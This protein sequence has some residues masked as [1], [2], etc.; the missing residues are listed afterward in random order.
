MRILHGPINVGNQPWVLSRHERRLGVHSDL[1]VAA[2]N[3]FKF[4]ADRHLGK[5]GDS[6]WYRLWKR[7][8]FGLQAPLRYDVIHYYYG[9]SFVHWDYDSG[10]LPG[11]FL[12]LKLAKRFGRKVF[13]T[14]QGCDVRLSDRKLDRSAR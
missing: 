11:K 10:K 12:D 4:P 7:S 14:L 13:M 2:E 8:W 1:V 6:R 3:G 5:Q 9:R